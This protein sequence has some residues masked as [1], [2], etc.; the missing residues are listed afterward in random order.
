MGMACPNCHGTGIPKVRCDQCGGTGV[1]SATA[2]E[3]FEGNAQRVTRQSIC[4]KCVRKGYID[5]PGLCQ[6]CKA[7][8][9][10]KIERQVIDCPECHGFGQVMLEVGTHPSGFP[11]RQASICPRCQGQKR[12]EADVYVPDFG[13]VK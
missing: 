11:K 2:T 3:G 12:V 13:T 1:Y 9:R 7:T 4:P 5:G 10:V 6:V 8:G